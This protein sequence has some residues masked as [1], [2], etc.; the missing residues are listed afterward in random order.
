MARTGMLELPS[1]LLAVAFLQANSEPL[2]GPMGTLPVRDLDDDLGLVVPGNDK[3]AAVLDEE[4]VGLSSSEVL[5]KPRRSEVDE[6]ASCSAVLSKVSGAVLGAELAAA[7][8][9][10]L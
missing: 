6:I 8:L 10:P 7:E 3:F 9:C 1:A 5:H 4:G 2:S